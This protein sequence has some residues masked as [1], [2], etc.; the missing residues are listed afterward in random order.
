MPGSLLTTFWIALGGALGT[1][2]RYWVGMWMAPYS[3]SMPWGTIVIN[4]AGSFAITFF[5][6]LTVISGRHPLPETW[7]LFFM[8]GIC[9][10]FTTFSSFSLQTLDLLRQGAP[11]RALANV[12][13]S[14]L[15]CLASATLGYAAARHLNGGIGQIAQTRVEE[16]V[17]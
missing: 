1:V 5:G 16:D 9:G 8:V 15:L 6:T 17:S 3:Q 11:E 14:V 13:M 12:A 2:A 7:R 4:I 10:G